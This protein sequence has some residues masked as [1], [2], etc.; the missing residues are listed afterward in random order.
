VRFRDLHIAL[1][2]VN[3]DIDAAFDLIQA[4]RNIWLIGNGGSAAIASHIAVDFTKNAA[5]PAMAFNDASL[6]TCYANDFGYERAFGQAVMDK[7][8]HGD[9]L[10]AISSSGQSKNIINA[11]EAARLLSLNVLTLSGFKA[12]NP[13]RAMGDVNLYVPAHDYGTVEITHLAILHSMVP[14]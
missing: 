3:G 7:A 8:K 1:D 14:V 12:D 6:L 4:S 13:L 5:I 2:N 9:C 10:I 11:V